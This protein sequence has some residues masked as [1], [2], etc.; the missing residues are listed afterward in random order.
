[1]C[2]DNT[3]FE[4]VFHSL[5]K[6]EERFVL[7][8]SGHTPCTS[9]HDKILEVEKESSPKLEE[10]VFIATLQIFQSH[11]SAIHPKPLVLQI[12]HQKDFGISLNFPLHKGSFSAYS[13]NLL[14]IFLRKIFKSNPFE[15]QFKKLKDGMSSDAI[16]GER[17]HLETTLILSPSIPTLDIENEPISNPIIDHYGLFY[18]LS[19]KPPDDS[20]NSSRYPMHRNHQG[21]MKEQHPWLES[22]KNICA[23]AIGWVDKALDKINSRDDPREF[24]DIYESPLEVENDGDFHELGNYFFNTPSIPCSYEQS[25][26]SLS[27]SNIVSHEIFNPLLL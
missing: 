27:L 19:S 18:A 11:E 5:S 12:H 3:V 25:P 14:K 24:L 9:L 10:G 21:H 22:I 2:L 13:L 16:K 6:S 7:I 8:I 17:S 20:R 23:I 1:M 4:G 15:G 26:D